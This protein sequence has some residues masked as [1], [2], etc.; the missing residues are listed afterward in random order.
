MSSQPPLSAQ[1]LILISAVFL[2]TEP[3]VTCLA[4]YIALL[5]AAL[6]SN[7]ASYPIVFQQHRGWTAGQGG[8]AFLGIGVGLILGNCLAPLQDGLYRREM[9]HNPSGKA[10]PEAYVVSL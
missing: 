3:I 5:Y 7:F 4:V 8:L 6:Y 1:Y 9:R 10:P 2:F